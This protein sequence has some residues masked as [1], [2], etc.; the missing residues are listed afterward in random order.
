MDMACSGM[1][2]V[3]VTL[4]EPAMPAKRY[5]VTLT[6]EERHTLCD[7]LKKGPLAARKLARAHILLLA[8]EGR[9]DDEI[10]AALH[11]GRATV[12]R[13]RKRFVED[14]F[15]DALTERPRPGKPALLDAKQEAYVIATAC[16]SPPSGR[17]RWSVRLLAD[18]LVRRSIVDEISRET[19]RRT[20]K[21]TFSSPG[22]LRNG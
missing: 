20:L 3:A 2:R 1:L 21:K 17:A 13:V 14:G 15:E 22:R 19:V 16:S 5:I 7:L 10:A 6:D 4:Q 9:P 12:E 18:E 11:V 8:D